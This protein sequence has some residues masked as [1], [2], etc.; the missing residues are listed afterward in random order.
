MMMTKIIATGCRVMIIDD[1][2]D[3]DDIDDDN[4]DDTDDNDHRLQ[5]DDGIFVETQQV[6]A[7]WVGKRLTSLTFLSA[8][9]FSSSALSQTGEKHHQDHH[10]ARNI[11]GWSIFIVVNCFSVLVLI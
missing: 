11:A 2:D 8:V 3:V 7:Q 1:E 9:P 6:A 10:Y 4:D 5:G